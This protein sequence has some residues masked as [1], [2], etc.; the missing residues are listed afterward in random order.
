MTGMETPEHSKYCIT[1]YCHT[2]RAYSVAFQ[3]QPV[4][5]CREDRHRNWTHQS[6]PYLLH[7][8]QESGGF[9]RADFCSS[10]DLE[11]RLLLEELG[12]TD[13]LPPSLTSSFLLRLFARVE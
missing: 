8:P 7:S 9:G 3:L 13:L 1:L 10:F 4:S 2:P 6:L 11:C 5:M 12:S